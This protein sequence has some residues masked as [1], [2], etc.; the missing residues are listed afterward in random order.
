MS[1]WVPS[2]KGRAFLL[3]SQPV[4]YL[5]FCLE[6]SPQNP[7]FTAELVIFRKNQDGW[8]SAPGF[9]RH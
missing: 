3:N 4:I 2:K 7:S 6:L 8:K 1:A 9:V 5:S